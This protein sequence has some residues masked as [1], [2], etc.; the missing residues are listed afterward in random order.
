MKA[1]VS[2]VIYCRNKRY[3]YLWTL[4]LVSGIFHS[5]QRFQL[6]IIYHTCRCFAV[7]WLTPFEQLLKSFKRLFTRYFV[8]S[9]SPLST[10]W[11][12][13]SLTRSFGCPFQLIRFFLRSFF[14]LRVRLRLRSLFFILLIINFF[15]LFSCFSICP[16]N[17][18][19]YSWA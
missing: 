19:Y 8:L 16:V 14:R 12:V 4:A 2:I 5:S 17:S 15:F 1:L 9:F 3:L 18:S 6:N 13:W 11:T 10:Q 7:N